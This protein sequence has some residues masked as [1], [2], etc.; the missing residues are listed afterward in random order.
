M[1]DRDLTL[2]LANRFLVTRSVA[3]GYVHNLRNPVQSIMMAASALDSDMTTD[4]AEQMIPVV[5]SEADRAHAYLNVLSDLFLEDEVDPSPVPLEPLLHK[6]AE[7]GYAMRPRTGV[8]VNTVLGAAL[9]AVRGTELD[10]L[11]IMLNLLSNAKW[12]TQHATDQHIV[13]TA[14]PDGQVVHVSVSDNGSGIPEDLEGDPFDAH[15]TGRKGAAGIGLTASR[16]L[17][18]RYDATLKLGIDP[19]GGETIAK[20]SLRVW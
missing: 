7:L 3:A 19:I 18:E 9:P 12:A 2:L 5:R 17:A 13:I 16:K 10:L 6:S 4:T 20:L 15:V 11:M 14:E 1:Q 8:E